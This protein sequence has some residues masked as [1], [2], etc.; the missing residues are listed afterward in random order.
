MGI[1]DIFNKA[2]DYLEKPETKEK[3]Q[4]TKEKTIELSKKA[5]SEFDSTCAKADE[6]IK[7]YLDKKKQEKDNSETPK[8]A[9]DN[10]DENNTTSDDN[11]NNDVSNETNAK[12]DGENSDEIKPSGEDKEQSEENI[13]DENKK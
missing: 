12:K 1:K 3:I 7:A 8:P 11:N 4:K 10:N 13:S 2:K 6:K 5:K 9:E